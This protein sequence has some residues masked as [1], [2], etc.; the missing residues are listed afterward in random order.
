METVS[1]MDIMY[2]TQLMGELKSLLLAVDGSPYSDGAIKEAILLAKSCGIRLTMLYILG[3]SDGFESGGLT[4]VEHADTAMQDYF[5]NLREMAVEENVEMD[6][7]VRRTNDTYKGILEEAYEKKS[8]VIIMGRRGMTGLKRVLMGSV[9]AKVIAYAPCKVLVVPKEAQIKG[10]NIML[11]TDGSRYS[12]A[13]TTEAINMAKRCP[14]VKTFTGL[15]V[16]P[17]SD[18]LGESKAILQKIKNTAQKEGVDMQEVITVGAPYETIVKTAQERN[19]NVILMGT[20][21]RTGIEKLLMG[22]VAERVVALSPCS[23][24]V[25]KERAYGN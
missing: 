23:V 5:D 2:K 6:I 22:S 25:I 13:A 17:S 18:R 3:L 21:G 1:K 12:E 19:I 14:Q 20:H 16:A 4:L 9:T 11:A 24:L 7:V 10:E 15:S 8:D